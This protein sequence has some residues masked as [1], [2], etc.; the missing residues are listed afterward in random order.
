MTSRRL[1]GFVDS[2]EDA[3]CRVRGARDVRIGEYGQELRWRTAED[4]WRVDVTH[5][6][7]QRG[8]HRLQSLLGGADSIGFDEKDSEVALIAMRARELVLE[9]GAHKAIVEEA[10]GAID[11]VQGLG[12]RVVHLDAASGAEDRARR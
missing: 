1:Q 10:C 2:R 7:G 4:A 9:H 5:R 11:D 12:L 6:A 8:R 3:I